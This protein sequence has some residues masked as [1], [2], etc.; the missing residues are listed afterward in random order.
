MLQITYRHM[1]ST[2]SL[3]EVAEEK[4]ARL[5]SHFAGPVRCH[6]V[7][8]CRTGHARKGEQFTAHADLTIGREDTRIDAT[9]SH[10]Q[11]ACAVREVFARLERQL[12]ARQERRAAAPI[13]EPIS[14]MAAETQVA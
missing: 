13:P 14:A 8:D 1:T 3:R 10:A 5:T 9:V 12:T 11:A 4:F 2:D 6:L 7:I